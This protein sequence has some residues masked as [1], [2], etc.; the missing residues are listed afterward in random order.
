VSRL[1]AA[2]PPLTAVVGVV[3]GAV[4]GLGVRSHRP[5]YHDAFAASAAGTLLYVVILV[6][7]AVAGVYSMPAGEPG[8]GPSAAVAFFEPLVFFPVFVVETL[9]VAILVKRLRIRVVGDD[10]IE[11]S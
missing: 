10:T 8:L 4:V 5:V 7:G 2:V 9:V 1:T 11:F 3:A 6:L